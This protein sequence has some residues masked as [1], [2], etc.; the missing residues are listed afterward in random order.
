MVRAIALGKTRIS[1]I[2]SVYK[3]IVFIAHVSLVMQ[4]LVGIILTFSDQNLF[5]LLSVL[6]VFSF[7]VKISVC[8]YCPV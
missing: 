1:A 8:S 7:F 3:Y 4:T 2:D 5:L 6:L